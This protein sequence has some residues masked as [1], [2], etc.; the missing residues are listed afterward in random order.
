MTTE[1]K[2]AGK[3]PDY[4]VFTRGAGDNAPNFKIGSAWSVK[5]GGISVSLVANPVDGKIVLFPVQDREPVQEP[6]FQ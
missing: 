1:S 6:D 3:K 2:P 5:K 4:N